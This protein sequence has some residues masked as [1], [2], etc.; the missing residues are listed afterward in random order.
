MNIVL[1]ILQIL[2]GL[3]FIAAGILKATQPLDR[4]GQQ[5]A[6]VKDTPPAMV[7]FI[8]V[9]ELL[10]GVGLILPAATGIL[11]WL[12][13]VAALAL[14]VV[15]VLAAGVHARRNEFN[16]IAPSLVLLVL[17]VVIVVGRFAIVPF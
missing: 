4:L 7:R 1:W 14:A 2:V 15:M 11:P 3:A 8:G 17:A 6:W 10:G 13:P 12:T 16:R 5:M 9:A